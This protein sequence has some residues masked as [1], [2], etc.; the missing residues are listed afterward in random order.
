MKD[1]KEFDSK[2]DAKEIDDLNLEEKIKNYREINEKYD[3][4]HKNIM[5]VMN[6]NAPLREPK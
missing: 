2:E 6:K 3:F 5:K 4:F 1:L